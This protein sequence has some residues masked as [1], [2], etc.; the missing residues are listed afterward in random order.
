MS[1]DEF[2]EF[3]WNLKSIKSQKKTIMYGAKNS[4]EKHLN[5]Y[6]VTWAWDL[7]GFTIKDWIFNFYEFS[8]KNTWCPEI[9]T[10]NPNTYINEDFRRW[11][12]YLLLKKVIPNSN[13][14]IIIWGTCCR[15]FLR[16]LN[17]IKLENKQGNYTLLWKNDILYK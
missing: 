11:E 16:I 13:I 3:Y 1:W 17:E 8:T 15:E 4:F 6:W 9:K 7:D 12:A 14:N 10:H 2:A 5:Y